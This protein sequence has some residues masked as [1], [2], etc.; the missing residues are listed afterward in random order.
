MKEAGQRLMAL[1]ISELIE[2]FRSWDKPRDGVGFNAFR[3]ACTL[4]PGFGEAELL[5]E[6]SATDELPAELFEW[7]SYT[8][9]ADLFVDVDHGQWGL[10]IFGPAGCL[11]RTSQERE[12]R[13]D[14]YRAT[15]LVLGE[16]LG[17]LEL[18]VLTEQQNVLVALPLDPRDDWHEVGESLAQFFEQYLGAIGEKFWEL[19]R[20]S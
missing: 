20:T 3:L 7:W 12:S 13:P 14:A 2:E 10:R 4:E 19:K 16:F 8:G 5:D 15:D 11:E 9:N 1:S 17:D 18:L 6:W